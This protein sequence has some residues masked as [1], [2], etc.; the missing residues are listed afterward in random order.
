MCKNYVK[1][2]ARAACFYFLLALL[3]VKING[4]YLKKKMICFDLGLFI[5]GITELQAFI[6]TK[7]SSSWTVT[8]SRFEP[9]KMLPGCCITIYWSLIFFIGGLYAQVLQRLRKSIKN[10]FLLNVFTLHNYCNRLQKK[11][12]NSLQI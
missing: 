3:H 9:I 5:M 2:I 1:K 10:T 8:C 7:S 4:T 6:I 12:L 11:H